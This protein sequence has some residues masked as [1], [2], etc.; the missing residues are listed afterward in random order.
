MFEVVSCMAI[1]NR[2]DELYVG[3]L[4]EQAAK[5]IPAEPNFYEIL[6][7]TI[8]IKLHLRE[9][10]NPL[11]KRGIPFRVSQGQ[12]VHLRGKRA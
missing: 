5:P 4:Q 7:L 12:P 9:L 10:P 11:G 1:F 8:I 2:S 3:V 6:Y